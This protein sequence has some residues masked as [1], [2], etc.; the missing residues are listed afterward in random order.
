MKVLTGSQ[1]SFTGFSE[2]FRCV[3]KSF[4]GFLRLLSDFHKGL[5]GVSKELHGIAWVL[6]GF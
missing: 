1:M 5:R 3:S 4:W 2:G 6:E